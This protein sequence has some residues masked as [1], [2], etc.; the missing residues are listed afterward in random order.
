MRAGIVV[1]SLNQGRF[2]ASAIDSLLASR[3]VP[4]SIAVVDGGSTDESARIV[5]RYRSRLSYY[6]SRQDEGQ[7]AAVNEGVAALVAG[8]PD[9]GYVGFLNADDVLLDLGLA[10]L[11]R[12]LEAHPEFVAVA[13]RAHIIAESGAIKGEYPS[14]P[15]SRSLFARRCTICQPATLIRRAAWESAGG[16]DPSLEMCLDYDLWWR[17][18][19]IGPIGFTDAIVAASRDHPATKT[20]TR[21]EQ[22]FREAMQI[23]RREYGRVP[24]HWYISE[25]LER[26]AGWDTS[27]RPAFSARLRAGVQALRAYLAERRPGGFPQWQ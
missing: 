7:A 27:V 16:L 21:R 22:Y 19:S 12:A 3:E 13:G 18:S 11:V 8:V 23:V 6:R 1:P 5:E 25:A 14:A 15:F 20:R 2:L 24:W 26:Q 4:V 9:L 10:A 17:L